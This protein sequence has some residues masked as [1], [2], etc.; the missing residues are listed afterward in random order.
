MTPELKA[1]IEDLRLNHEYCP[2][3]VILQAADELERL[4]KPEPMFMRMPT[5]G[6][7]IICIE[8]DS[9][10][11]VAYLT[12]GGSPEIRFDDGSHGT[13]LLREFAKLFRYADITPPQPEQEPVAQQ[14][15]KEPYGYMS[16]CGIFQK[17]KPEIG[18]WET[19]YTTPPRRT[20][21]GLTDEEIQAVAKQARSKDHAVTLTNKF[22][23]EKNL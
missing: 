7:K 8:D 1:L 12:A 2:R 19:L 4:A 15:E 13:Y 9:L 18:R 11:T 6:D 10:G 5:V 3:E 21:V 23:R 20:W 16:D 14:E 22:L 17:E